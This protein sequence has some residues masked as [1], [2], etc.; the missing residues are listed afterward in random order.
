V[1]VRIG[2]AGPFPFEERLVPRWKC[3]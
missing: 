3:G 1:G 2:G